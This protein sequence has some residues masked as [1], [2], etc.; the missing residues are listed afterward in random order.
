MKKLAASLA[1]LALVLPAAPALAQ[2]RSDQG[3]ARKEMRAG[4]VLSLRQ[5][6][7]RVLPNMRGSE[8]LGPAYDSTAMAYRL[9]F[10]RDGRVT[11]VDVDART[12]RVLGVS[13]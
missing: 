11:Y 6:E 8:Y 5:I 10:I 13:R 9:K 12:G 1:V 7:S 2:Q 4:N 3:E